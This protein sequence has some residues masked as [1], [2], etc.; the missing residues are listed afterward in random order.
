MK[1]RILRSGETDINST[2][3]WRFVLHELYPT[4]KVARQG[5]FTFSLPIGTETVSQVITHNLGYLPQCR[6]AVVGWDGYLVRVSGGK[7]F[8]DA[9][10][11]NSGFFS[12]GTDSTELI[13]SAGYYTASTASRSFACYYIILE[14]E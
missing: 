5:S 10:M 8:Y 2:D 11:N 13:I 4:Q 14:D 1:A 9:T 7:E 12:Y 6:V 3:I